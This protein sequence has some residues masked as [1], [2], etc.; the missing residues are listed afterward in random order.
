[1]ARPNEGLALLDGYGISDLR[2]QGDARHIG[3]LPQDIELFGGAIRDVIGRFD[4]GGS[5]DRVLA[6]A[7]MP[8]G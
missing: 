6:D 2:A 4:V 5:Y 8:D 3:Y 1:M 7:S